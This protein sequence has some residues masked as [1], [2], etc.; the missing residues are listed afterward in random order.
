MKGKS[1]VKLFM[2]TFNY[3]CRGNLLKSANIPKYI[4]YLATFSDLEYA[5]YFPFKCFNVFGH[6]V[7]IPH[8]NDML[9]IKTSLFLFAP[10]RE[11][12]VR[13]TIKILLIYASLPVRISCIQAKN[14][15]IYFVDFQIFSPHA[16][17]HK[18]QTYLFL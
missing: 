13:Y 5:F 10:T 9:F 16:Y 12:T 1:L 17:T 4:R 3:Q 14:E 8:Q 15:Q 7:I 18:M 6:F 2:N 11:S